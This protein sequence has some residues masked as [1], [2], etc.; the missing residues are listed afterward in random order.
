MILYMLFSKDINIEWRRGIPQIPP[1]KYKNEG[2]IS[3]I[4]WGKINMI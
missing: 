1:E 4:A 3:I 2:R